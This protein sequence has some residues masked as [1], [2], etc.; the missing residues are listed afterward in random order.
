MR[1]KVNAIRYVLGK[2]M[3]FLNGCKSIYDV[4]NLHLFVSQAMFHIFA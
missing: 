3:K 1:L 2:I 4:I